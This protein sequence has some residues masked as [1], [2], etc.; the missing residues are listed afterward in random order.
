[1]TATIQILL[2]RDKKKAARGESERSLPAS[3]D[4]TSPPLQESDVDEKKAVRVKD[5][6]LVSLDEKSNA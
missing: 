3:E 1:V 6:P 2:W 5:A 4:S